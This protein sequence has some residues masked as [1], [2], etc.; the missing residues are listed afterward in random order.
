M[1]SFFVVS[2]MR[3]VSDESTKERDYDLCAYEYCEAFLDIPVEYIEEADFSRKGLEIQ[4]TKEKSIYSEDW[5][6]HLE[7]VARAR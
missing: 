2:F 1:Q 6:I 4:L 3:L 7:R 5:Y